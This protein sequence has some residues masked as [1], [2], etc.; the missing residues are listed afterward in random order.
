MYR[1]EVCWAFLPRLAAEDHSWS[2]CWL[3][4]P[5]AKY[6]QCWNSRTCTECQA[7]TRWLQNAAGC[8]RC[9]HRQFATKMVVTGLR[10]S[11]PHIS[12]PHFFAVQPLLLLTSTWNAGTA[13]RVCSPCPRLYITVVVVISTTLCGEIWTWV[14]HTVVVTS[15]PHTCWRWR[16]MSV[17]QSDALNCSCCLPLKPQIYT[18]ASVCRWLLLQNVI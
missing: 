4:A 8:C 14:S 9:N 6:E 2:A 3:S 12:V 15:Q 18:I 13:I 16:V 17:T 11:C 1:A 10:H 7:Y 5:P